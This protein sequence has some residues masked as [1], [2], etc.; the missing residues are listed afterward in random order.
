LPQLEGIP[1]HA[2]VVYMGRGTHNLYTAWIPMGDAPFEMGGLAI[3]EN[4]RLA[5]EQM[6]D[7][8]SIDV[9]SYCVNEKRLP[10]KHDALEARKRFGFLTHDTEGLRKQI[11]TRWLTADYRAG[12]F[13]TFH[14]PTT[15]H[16]VTDNQSD[17]YLLSTDSRY[18]PAD[19][20]ADERWIGSPPP[21][22]GG[23]MVKGMVC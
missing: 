14:V 22:H 13:L 1:P 11:G 16:G 19:E 15:I 10:E 6:R 23:K 2:D 7:Y 18:Q 17:R 3:L 5:R 4:S 20:P 21:G 9:D 12:D 8:Y